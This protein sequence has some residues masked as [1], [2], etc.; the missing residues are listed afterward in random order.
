M[1][2]QQAGHLGSQTILR[3]NLKAP[4]LVNNLVNHQCQG[5][6]VDTHMAGVVTQAVT[7]LEAATDLLV[8][9]TCLLLVAEAGAASNSR[10]SHHLAA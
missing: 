4:D 1:T 6:V 7:A 10:D 5:V 2:H 8:N 3:A 9:G